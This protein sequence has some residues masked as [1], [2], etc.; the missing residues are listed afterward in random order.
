M[1][2]PLAL[3]ARGIRK[4]RS[5]GGNSVWQDMLVCPRGRRIAAVN[6]FA[7]TGVSFEWAGEV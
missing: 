2:S 1:E 4:D 5:V 7:N 3:F 6:A